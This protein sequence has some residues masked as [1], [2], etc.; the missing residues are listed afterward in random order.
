MPRLSISEARARLP[1]LARQVVARPG[2]AVVIENQRMDEAVV[3]TSERHLRY[4]EAEVEGLRKR[5]GDP[6]ALAGSAAT[7]LDADELAAALERLRSEQNA[8]A[9]GRLSELADG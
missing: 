8:A 3:L 4:L 7:D 2:T 6:F 1:E 5:V 9:L